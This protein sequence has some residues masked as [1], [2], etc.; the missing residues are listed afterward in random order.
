MPKYSNSLVSYDDI[1]ALKQSVERHIGRRIVTPA[2]FDFLA[3][4]ISCDVK[5]SVSATTLK[6]V[7][8]YIND[9]G[10]DYR[11]GRYTLCAL[12]LF[13]GYPD[14][15]TF[16][17]QLPNADSIQSQTYKGLSLISS[18]LPDD[19]LIELRWSPGRI[20]TLRHI[21]GD[22]FEVL[23]SVNSKLRAGDIVSCAS[24]ADFTP[25]WFSKV[26]RGDNN[27][28]SYIA[29]ARNGIRYTILDN[30]I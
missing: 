23:R 1:E 20:V 18:S 27:P 26:V 8:G 21:H 4:A 15:E 9:A 3:D 5:Q 13:I 10:A 6:R 16:V 7:W 25:A 11:P 22:E 30:T 12:A 14:Y 29:G 28:V 2:D 17:A 19:K 24:F